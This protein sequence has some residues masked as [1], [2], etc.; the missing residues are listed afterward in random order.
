M[1]HLRQYLLFKIETIFKQFREMSTREGKTA[2]ENRYFRERGKSRCRQ[3]ESFKLFAKGG[4]LL[5]QTGDFAA[6]L[7]HFFAQRENLDGVA[8]S[9]GAVFGG[10]VCAGW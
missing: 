9:G 8:C 1:P 4:E 6:Q 7:R 10:L 5:L 2:R 3:S